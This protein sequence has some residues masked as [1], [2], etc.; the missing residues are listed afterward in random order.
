MK[1]SASL[2]SRGLLALLLAASSLALSAAPLRVLLIDGQNN[3]D[4][5]S[6]SPWIKEVLESSGLFQVDVATTTPKGG[7]MSVFKPDLKPYRAVV[8]NYNG[9]PWSKEFQAAF[10]EYVRNGGG[11]VSVHAADN[12]FP[13]WQEYNEMIGV[14]GWNGRNEKSGPWLYWEEKIV[15]DTSPGVGGSHGK[16]HAFKM[17][18]REP[19]HPIMAGLPAEWM[20]SKDELYD[21]LRG[22]AKNITVLATAFADKAQNGTGRNEPLLMTLS[23]GGGRI[24]HTALGHNNGPDLAAQ[25]C[26]GFIVTLQRGTEWAATGQVTQKVPADFPTSDKVSSR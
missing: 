20:H 24:F 26:V 5:K 15:R 13:D 7:D 19:A 2:F 9:E 6:S 25:K 10:T 14:G 8:S 23:F 18:T 11:F 16:Q 4:W 1:S 17:I 3:H 21:R 12:A 22:P